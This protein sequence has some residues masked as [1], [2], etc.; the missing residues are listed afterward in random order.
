MTSWFGVLRSVLWMCPLIGLSV[1]VMGSISL[2]SSLFDSTGR[3]QHRVAVRWARMVLGICRVKVDVVGAANLDPS[4]EYVFCS[5]HFSLIDT[6]V[7][8]GCMP[9]EFR[10][11][12]RHGLWKIP[13]LGWHLNRA[14]HLPVHRENPRVAARSIQQA[15]EKVRAGYSVFLF[16]EGGRTREDRMRPFKPGAGYIAIRAGAAVVP[17]AIVGTRAIL[18]PNSLN[19]RPGRAELR[20]GRPIPADGLEQRDAK[21][22]MARV[23]ETILDLSQPRRADG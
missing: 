22:L 10:I 15:A 16:P 13:F 12:A 9:R 18:P 14:G 19:L 8:F 17:M 23:R 11:L 2:I 6:P 4:R 21:E 5:N 1:V 3:L 7:V 20:I